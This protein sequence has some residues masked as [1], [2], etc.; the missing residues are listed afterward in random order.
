MWQNFCSNRSSVL[1]A[2]CFIHDMSVFYRE[3]EGN[4]NNMQIATTKNN[5]NFQSMYAWNH[6][7]F[8][9][10]SRR[11]KKTT[12]IP[13]KIHWIRM[14][15]VEKLTKKKT[16][17]VA[18]I[19]AKEVSKYSWNYIALIF[20][21]HKMF[22]RVIAFDLSLLQFYWLYGLLR[23]FADLATFPRT[24]SPPIFDVLKIFIHE[25]FQIFT[26]DNCTIWTKINMQRVVFWCFDS[27]WSITGLDYIHVDVLSMLWLCICK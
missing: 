20:K 7:L 18:S 12:E 15:R 9:N 1:L 14:K 25:K 5:S 23:I 13:K 21:W 17:I 3:T 16:Q 26:V 4:P 11:Q 8:K 24:N 27:I 6:V 19:V 10:A 22:T 2:I